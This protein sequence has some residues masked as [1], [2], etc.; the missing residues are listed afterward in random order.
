MLIEVLGSG[1]QKCIKTF[2]LAQEAI[3]KTGVEAEIIKIKDINTI[4]NYGV[5]TTPALAI[6]GKVK[7]A[8]RIPKQEYLEKWIMEEK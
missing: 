6:N 4:T 3:K 7:I 2:E 8:G 5:M 1:C